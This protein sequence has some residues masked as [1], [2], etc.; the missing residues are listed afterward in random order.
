MRAPTSAPHHSGSVSAGGSAATVSSSS[1]RRAPTFSSIV[2]V[3]VSA[4]M[5]SKP[6]INS[7]G[8]TPAAREPVDDT[9]QALHG[10]GDIVVG[11]EARGAEVSLGEIPGAYRAAVGGSPAVERR[12]RVDLGAVAPPVHERVEAEAGEEL[13][14]LRRVTEGV[15]H[16]RDARRATERVCDRAPAQQVAH[17]CLARR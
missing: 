2:A 14:E 6:F 5:W 17:V 10:G 7:T 15:G 12:E 1:A 13:R 4:G 8:P 11:V 3:V 16:V 9:F